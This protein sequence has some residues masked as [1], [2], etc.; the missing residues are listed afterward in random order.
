MTQCIPETFSVLD[1]NATHEWALAPAQVSCRRE[2]WNFL[3]IQPASA[4]V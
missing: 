3:K 1:L 2:K 4:H